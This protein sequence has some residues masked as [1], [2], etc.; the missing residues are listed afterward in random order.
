[1]SWNN[2]LTAICQRKEYELTA[3]EIEVL[4]CLD[5]GNC[6]TKQDLLT[7]CISLYGAIEE[8]A[9]TQRLKKYLQKV[10]DYWRGL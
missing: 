1:M 2:F 10:S 8:E 5:E 3:V 7:N 6:P 4:M 9:F